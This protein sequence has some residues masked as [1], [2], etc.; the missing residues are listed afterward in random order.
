MDQSRVL[1]FCFVFSNG[2]VFKSPQ[3][4]IEFAEKHAPSDL[5]AKVKAADAE[6]SEEVNL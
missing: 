1:E 6:N 3:E 5:Y 2:A 4:A